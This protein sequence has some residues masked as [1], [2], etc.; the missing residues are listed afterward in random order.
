LIADVYCK[1]RLSRATLA[2]RRST[3]ERPCL[4]VIGVSAFPVRPAEFVDA[5]REGGMS[6]YLNRNLGRSSPLGD[7]ASQSDRSCGCGCHDNWA[8]SNIGIRF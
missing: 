3:C 7:V 5:A 6:G 1:R 8:E 2:T 4:H